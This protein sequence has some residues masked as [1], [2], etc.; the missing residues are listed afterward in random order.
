MLIAC[1]HRG[2]GWGLLTLTEGDPLRVLM[3]QDRLSAR[4]GADWYLLSLLAHLKGRV[5]TLLAVGYDDGSLPLSERTGLGKWV[6]LKGLERSG[7]GGRRRLAV[8]RDFQELA[9]DFKPEVIHLHNIM[10]PALLEAAA[11]LGRAIMSVQDHRLFCPGLGQVKPDHNLC[12][13]VLGPGCQE[14]FRQ[15]DYGRRMIDLTRRRL[16][17]A[18]SLAQLVVLSDYM[19]DQLAAAGVAKERIAI[20]P[21][22]V[23]RLEA[24]PK[25]TPGRYHLLAGRLV[26]RKGL[27]VA[28]KAR[29]LMKTSLPLVIAGDGARARELACLADNGVRYVGWAD[30][31]RLA[32]LLFGARCLWLP[33]LWAEP[34]GIVGLEA[35]A[36]GVPVIASEVGGVGEWL[37]EGLSGCL[38]P[39]NR[40]SE[41][42]QAADRLAADAP[43]ARRLGQAGQS[44]VEQDFS[45]AGIM[46]RLMEIYEQA[47]CGG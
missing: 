31:R 45:P 47:A 39:P 9:A 12:G 10:D 36:A 4:G 23:Y 44:R 26:D 38:V 34:F 43:L 16:D 2:A 7:L 41:L 20:L 27:S 3:V 35:L 6:R 1:Q 24:W 40:P 8:V 22:F 30:R 46:D 18:G 21:P 32:A 13:Q 25:K 28:L 14:C 15:D 19:A 29:G 42:A 37:T 5:E 33:S 17:A 11:G